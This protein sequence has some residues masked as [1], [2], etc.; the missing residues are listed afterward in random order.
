MKKV[1]KLDELVKLGQLKGYHFNP[2]A[3][4]WG[5]DHRRRSDQLVLT[6]PDGNIL[7]LNT[8]CS[9]TSEDTHI[10]IS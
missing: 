1:E 3:S 7:T 5:F 4:I 10:L 2:Q 8:I 6:F 9:G